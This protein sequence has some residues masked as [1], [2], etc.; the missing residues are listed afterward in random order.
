[1][2]TQP[3]ATPRIPVT[4]RPVQP[5][6]RRFGFVLAIV[7]QILMMAG[8]SAPSPFYPVLAQDL[9]FDAIVITA[10]FAVY[11]VALLLTL[12]TAGSLSDHV[13]RRPVI[14]AGLVLLTLPLSLV[15]RAFGQLTRGPRRGWS[16]PAP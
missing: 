4:T 10:V 15:L 8:A 14:I 9:G 7:A 12:L 3:I 2:T 5:A 6:S 13:G 1:M 16:S 11:A